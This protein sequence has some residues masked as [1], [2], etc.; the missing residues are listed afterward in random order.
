MLT[1]FMGLVFLKASD[2]SAFKDRQSQGHP[3]AKSSPAP[4]TVSAYI[5]VKALD[6]GCLALLLSTFSF[7]T[8]FLPESGAHSLTARLTGQ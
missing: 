7:G 4:S 2:C 3:D 8:V 6:T 5:H 1:E